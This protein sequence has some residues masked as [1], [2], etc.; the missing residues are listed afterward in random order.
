METENMKY[1]QQV[2]E[3]Q[4][5]NQVKYIIDEYQRRFESVNELARKSKELTK[6]DNKVKPESFANFCCFLKNKEEFD[7][8]PQYSEYVKWHIM[9]STLID[10]TPEKIGLEGLDLMPLVFQEKLKS[11]ISN[12][13]KF[14]TLSV[15]F[16]KTFQV[17]HRKLM[18]EYEIKVRAVTLIN[19]VLEYALK[20]NFLKALGANLC[21]LEIVKIFKN[22]GLTKIIINYFFFS[23]K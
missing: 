17:E 9:N 23:F 4:T 11:S 13:T 20:E 15:E 8:N 7:K 10:L 18:E 16:P 19:M 22:Y 12:L 21:M 6:G 1:A 3:Y 14:K 5:G 2:E